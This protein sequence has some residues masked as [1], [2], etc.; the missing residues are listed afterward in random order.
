MHHIRDWSSELIS[1]EVLVIH[2]H[3]ETVG[4]TNDCDK[5]LL[6]LGEWHFPLSLFLAP[7]TPHSAVADYAVFIEAR[8]EVEDNIIRI[9]STADVKMKPARLRRHTSDVN[10]PPGLKIVQLQK[11]KSANKIVFKNKS[12]NHH[13]NTMATRDTT[14]I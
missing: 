12:T 9:V 3:K 7:V 1:A 6:S 4:L 13:P 10:H 8:I 14:L 5:K 2:Q 11:Q